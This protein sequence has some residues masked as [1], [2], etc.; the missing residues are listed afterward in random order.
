MHTSGDA[1]PHRGH[2]SHQWFPDRGVV[3]LRQRRPPLLPPRAPG[4][5]QSEPVDRGHERL[6]RL[7]RLPP[8]AQRL[9]LDVGR[10]AAAGRAH[11]V[12]RRRDL[13]RREARRPAR[14]REQD[15]HPDVE[16]PGESPT[17]I[18]VTSLFSDVHDDAVIVTTK[19]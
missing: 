7:P 14:D 15:V 1:L 11:L 13:L 17:G 5:L 9:E 12:R 19:H 8:R 6:L 16:I 2:R 10:G 3:R 18:T 4:H